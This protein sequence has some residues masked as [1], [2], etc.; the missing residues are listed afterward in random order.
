MLRVFSIVTIY[1]LSKL[2]LQM[3]EVTFYLVSEHIQTYFSTVLCVKLLGF[4]HTEP[5]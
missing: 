2:E 5:R 1:V 3:C 4:N